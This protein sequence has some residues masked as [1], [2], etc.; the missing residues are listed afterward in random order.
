MGR[1]AMAIIRYAKDDFELRDPG[2]DCFYVPGNMEQSMMLIATGS[3]LAP[4]YGLIRDPL[5][6]PNLKNWCL[7][8]CGHP[9]MVRVTKGKA[10]P[11]GA[12]MK[13]IH[14]DAFNVSQPL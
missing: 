3:G 2:G 9:E 6:I 12:A 14:A 10:F 11:A 4:L 7:F 1:T 13:N 5:G 8:L